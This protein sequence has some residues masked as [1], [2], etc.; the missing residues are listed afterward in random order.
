MDQSS[1]P[2]RNRET[3]KPIR[4]YSKQSCRVPASPFGPRNSRC[5]VFIKGRL[6]VI[7]DAWKTAFVCKATWPL[8]KSELPPIRSLIKQKHLGIK[9]RIHADL[10]GAETW[11]VCRRWIIRYTGLD[12]WFSGNCTVWDTN[13][14]LRSKYL[15]RPLTP[16]DKTLTYMQCDGSG[17]N[18]ANIN[19]ITWLLK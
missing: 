18:R 2:V 6:R 15:W 14:Y 10:R 11:H 17:H 9:N 7:T 13:I 12:W 16:T 4:Q 1:D 3:G 19:N 5:I 8:H